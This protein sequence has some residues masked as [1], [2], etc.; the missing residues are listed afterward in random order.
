MIVF[1]DM[2]FNLDMLRKI[3]S[4]ISMKWTTYKEDMAYINI[5]SPINLSPTGDK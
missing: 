4:S 2:P 5:Y 1:Q 3:F